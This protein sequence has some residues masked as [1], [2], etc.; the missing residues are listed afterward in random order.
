MDSMPS[1]DHSDLSSETEA[2]DTVSIPVEAHQDRIQA[3]GQHLLGEHLQR[4]QQQQQQQLPYQRSHQPYPFYAIQTQK[5]EQQLV[6]H[7]QQQ[8]HHHPWP[9][10]IPGHPAQTLTSNLST[11]TQMPSLTFSTDDHS[12]YEYFLTSALDVIPPEMTSGIAS[13]LPDLDYLAE[14]SLRP[15]HGKKGG[16]GIIRR[17]FWTTGQCEV[18]LKSLIDTKHSAAKIASFFDKEVEVMRICGSHD[19]IVQFYGTAIKTE[20]GQVERLMVMRFYEQGDLVNLLRKPQY[21]PD[22]PTLNDRLFLALD[23]AV[24]LDYL[25]SCGF[26]HGDL[27]PRN[28]LV[29]VRQGVIPPNHYRGRYQARLTDFGLR[30]KRD[31]KSLNSSQPVA[32]VVQFMAPERLIQN[33]P[34]YDIRCD[35]FALGVIYWFLMSGRY[36]NNDRL[37]DELNTREERIQG[38]P[39]W[40]EAIYTQAWDTNPDWRQ[41]SLREIIH[42]FQKHLGLPSPAQSQTATSQSSVNPSHQGYYVSPTPSP[43]QGSPISPSMAHYD[44]YGPTVRGGFP[45]ANPTIHVPTFQNNRTDASNMPSTSAAAFAASTARSSN[46]QH[47]RNRQ[48]A[49]PNGMPARHRS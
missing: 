39:Q 45:M 34:R 22:A 19:N 29:D 44:M 49:V 42:V 14:F 33:R 41:Q 23:I 20:G 2:M 13:P 11:Q 37:A 24:G 3:Y 25:L 9:E 5:Q 38:T 15:D 1:L 30:R 28:I 12:D 47:P 46:P 40:Y 7:S 8:Q 18:V 21:L 35:T 10:N 17:A 32:G 6:Q 43:G 36:P 16:N 4:Q 31:N 48:P 26:H 27:H